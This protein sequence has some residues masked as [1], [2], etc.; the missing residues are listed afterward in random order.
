VGS[1]TAARP[2]PTP[3]AKTSPSPERSFFKNILRDQRAIWT[4]PFHLDRGDAKW[5]APIGLSTAALLATDRETAEAL[6][7]EHRTLLRVS[8][9]ISQGGSLYTTGGVVAAFYLVGR[10][11]HNAR[12]RET[13]VLGAEALIDGELVASALKLATQRPRP[14]EDN[15]SGEFFE[16]G[17]AFPSGHAVSSWALATV[18]AH[19][20]GRRRPLVRFGAYGLATAVSLSR[21]TARKHFLGDVLAGSAIGYGVG[22]YVY[23]T[24]H[25]PSLDEG[26]GGASGAGKHS[27]LMP[28]TSPIYYRASHSVGLMLVWTF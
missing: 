8:K 14:R 20:Y 10:A 15:G 28:F 16:G 5:L 12:A 3:Q 26:E 7:D 22:R 2:T 17:R 13:G 1:P 11:K 24:H 21:F 18:I 23:R 27:R 9:G 25:D 6:G 19:E 4:S